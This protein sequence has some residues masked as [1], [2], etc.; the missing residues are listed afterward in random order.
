MTDSHRQEHSEQWLDRLQ[1]MVDGTLDAKELESVTAHLK[2]CTDCRAEH[3]Q[4]SLVD[5]QLKNAFASVPVLSPDFSSRVFASVDAAE[6]LRKSTAKQLAERE[7]EARM[8]AFHLEWKDLWQR[9]MGSIVAGLSIFGALAATLSTMWGQVSATLL[10]NL[11]ALSWLSD[12]AALGVSIAAI[13]ITLSAAAL[14][15]LR[16]KTR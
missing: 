6:A 5:E 8:R 13:P 9:H 3:A 11:P 10:D 15:I 1:D 2:T 14:W 12:S 16:T 7:F 4:L